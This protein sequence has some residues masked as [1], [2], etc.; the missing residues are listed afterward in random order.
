MISFGASHQTGD[1]RS[2]KTLF[3]RQ[4]ANSTEGRIDDNITFDLVTGSWGGMGMG[5]ELHM[6]VQGYFSGEP[7]RIIWDM[8]GWAPITN[9]YMQLTLDYAKEP[10]PFFWG[11]ERNSTLKT[12]KSSLNKN[13]TR[14]FVHFFS[15]FSASFFLVQ[16]PTDLTN[17][18]LI[19]CECLMLRS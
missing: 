7:V 3:Y 18:L 11:V 16:K 2:C 5:N 17:P 1:C 15:P 19:L 10:S 12:C 9:V 4:G 13:R 6:S 14:G 8:L